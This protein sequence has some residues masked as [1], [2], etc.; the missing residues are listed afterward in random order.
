LA[1][2]MRTEFQTGH[3]DEPAR[4]VAQRIAEYNLLALPV[5]EESGDIL[6]IITV[7]DA[8]EILLPKD[9]RQRLPRLFG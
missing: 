4:D 6:G 1:E 7:D 8:M 5:V 2:V 3:P 9:W